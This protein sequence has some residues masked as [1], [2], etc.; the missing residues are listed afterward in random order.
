MTGIRLEAGDRR[1]PGLGYLDNITSIHLSTCKP[2]QWLLRRSRG[3]AAACR[4]RYG[5]RISGSGSRARAV[6]GH[7]SRTLRPT[8]A[9]SPTKI[10]FTAARIACSKTRPRRRQPGG[11]NDYEPA[12][13]F[14]TRAPNASLTC[15]NGQRTIVTRPR[16]RRTRPRLR[17]TRP[18]LRCT[19]TR[20]G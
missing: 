2:G 9:A 12:A 4:R 13:T 8:A 5:G 3:A 14:A 18:R 16:L 11:R 1:W 15:N 19:A 6:A 20:N 17:R 10:D 7:P